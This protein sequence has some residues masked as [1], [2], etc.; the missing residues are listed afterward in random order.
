MVSLEWPKEVLALAYLGYLNQHSN[1]RMGV[2]DE[3]VDK[4]NS[5]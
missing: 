4:F 3:P 5:Q 1:N 2:F